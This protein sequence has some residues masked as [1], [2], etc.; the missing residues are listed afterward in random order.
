M[1]STILEVTALCLLSSLG[2]R[3]SRTIGADGALA[4]A[5]APVAGTS[6]RAGQSAA[7]AGQSG[8]GAVMCGGAVCGVPAMAFGADLKMF[9]VDIRAC[10]AG[11][12]CGL[13]VV[14]NPAIVDVCIPV[15]TNTQAITGCPSYFDKPINVFKWGCCLPDGMCGEVWNGAERLGC[16]DR[17]ATN[18]T[19]TQPTTPCQPGMDCAVM[20]A[21]CTRDEDCCTI[22]PLGSRCIS[23]GA[24]S[25]CSPACEVDTD[26]STC[27]RPT[28]N[29]TKACAPSEMCL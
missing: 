19:A 5:T 25:V 26:C 12:V 7:Q 24:G 6:D 29:G 20:D 8:G 3:A 23:F 9:P 1:R 27:C 21:A 18:M 4:G 17:R 16:S 22:P 2:C 14:N 13:H 10:C 11:E 15:V 28:Q